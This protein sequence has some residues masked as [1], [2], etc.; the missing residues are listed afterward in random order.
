[1]PK[2]Q[3]LWKVLWRMILNLSKE[4]PGVESWSFFSLA[5]V[6]QWA[7]AMSGGFP[8]FALKM[9]EVLSSCLTLLCCWLLVSQPSSWS[10]TWAS[11]QPWAPPQFIQIYLHFSRVSGLPTFS[12][13]ASLVSITTSSLPG[14][15]TTS[16]PPSPQ[17]YPG[18]TAAMP[19]MTS[20]SIQVVNVPY[21][22]LFLAVCFSISEY[23]EC[24]AVRQSRVDT[25]N[26]IYLN[27]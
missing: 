19:T 1:M 6:T 25:E 9:E 7:W 12:P 27:R 5:W 14:P 17:T 18:S 24:E 11:T 4:E 22:P 23:K 10:S 20:V 13:S 21:E 16:S 3:Q 2:T 15:S 26:I 8:I